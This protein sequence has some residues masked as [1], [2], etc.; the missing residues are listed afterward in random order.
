[1]PLRLNLSFSLSLSLSLSMT[2]AF[3]VLLRNSWGL[4]QASDNTHIKSVRHSE[5]TRVHM[6]VT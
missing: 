4:L 3:E 2:V 6:Q 5:N 1:M